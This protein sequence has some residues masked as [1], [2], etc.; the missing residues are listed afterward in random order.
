MPEM[1]V[2]YLNYIYVGGAA[3][4]G[5]ILLLVVANFFRSRT[6]EAEEERP[7][8][9]DVSSL[10]DSGPNGTPTLEC[11]NVPTRLAAVVMAPSGRGGSMP[12]TPFWPKMLDA[13]VP[14]IGE[15]VERDQPQMIEWP[16]QLSTSGFAHTFFKL[17]PL[18]GDQGKSTPWC[19]LAGRCESE[20]DPVMVGLVMR[21]EKP[22]NLGPIRNRTSYQVVGR[23]S[24]SL[25]TIRF[26]CTTVCKLE[27]SWTNTEPISLP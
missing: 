9:L 19:S 12:P 10:G 18:P 4:L 7:S 1:I 25:S 2:P 22:N 5:L 20:F 6:S 13:S 17:V 26:D 8:T 27:L 24:C 11:Y 3:L 14:G 23:S 21:A 16:A 15:I